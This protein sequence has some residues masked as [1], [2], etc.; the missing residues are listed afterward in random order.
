MSYR[1]R[2][3]TEIGD[4]LT[5]LCSSD[6]VAAAEVTAALV[7]LMNAEDI[8]GLAMV[9][10]LATSSE[11]EP[12]DFR[13][14]ADYADQALLAA[15]QRMRREVA[16]IA[17]SR[18]RIEQRISAVEAASDAE[19]AKVARLRE[20][21]TRLKESERALTQRNQQ[22]QRAVDLFRAEKETAKAMYTAA[23]ASARV[24]A[25]LDEAAAMDSRETEP[26]TGEVVAREQADKADDEPTDLNRAL[27]EAEARLRETVSRANQMLRDLGE[28]AAP[29]TAPGLLELRADPFGDD[30]RILFAAKPPGTV[31][32]LA[33]IEGEAAI[34]LHRDRAIDLA[35]DLLSEIR[36]VGGRP[37]DAE[38]GELTFADTASFL[39]RFVP[40]RA[41]AVSERAA[42][43][44]AACSLEGLRSQRGLSRA[45]L[46]AAAGIAEQQVATLEAG[47]LRESYVLQIAEFVK[48]LGGRL[49]LSVVFDDDRRAVL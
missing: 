42:E 5:E 41:A 11:P 24:Q 40:A 8:I 9:T 19:P 31:A 37:D 17:N 44:A 22:I 10:D 3:S 7:A 28:S 2:M 34:S 45:E 21:C 14:A 15:L 35:S 29:R 12:A 16:E 36:S 13:A 43:L 6:P 38:S 48:A 39:E 26:D 18:Q 30:V 23:E 4:W 27:G 49:E 25:V 47:E 32:L 1:L 20:Q 46:A 33:V